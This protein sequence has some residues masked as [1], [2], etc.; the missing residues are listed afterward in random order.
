MRVHS[1]G[2]ARG[3][4]M[5][6]KS[7]SRASKIQVYAL[8]I[9]GSV[10]SLI[11]ACSSD[12]PGPAAGACTVGVPQSC[13][14]ATPCAAGTAPQAAC[15][16]DGTLGACTCTATQGVT[17]GTGG[18]AGRA[19]GVAVGT[20]GQAAGGAPAA[21]GGNTAPGTGGTGGSNTGPVAGGTGQPTGGTA[22]TPP[23]TSSNNWPMMGYDTNNNYHNPNEKILSVET[24]PM[25]KE[26]WRF[27]IAGYPPGTPII[28]DGRVF[29]HA[30][31]GTYG[32]SL[33]D[34][35]KLWERLDI[36]GTSSMGYA[37]G[38]VYVHV[39]N[40]DL[41]KLNPADGTTVWGPVKS[42]PTEGCDGESSP[43][44]AGG[45]VFVGHSC[46]P[47][48][49]GG[50]DFSTALGGVEA[51]DVETGE[52]K[53]TYYTVPMTGENGAMV[54]STVSVDVEAK[55]VFA[56]TGNNY[57]VQG[58]NSDAFHA[59]DMMTGTR[60]W[61]TQV[62]D[63][64]TW[65]LTG[66]PFGPDTD[67]GCNPILADIDGKKVAAGGEKGAAFHVFDRTTG[68]IVWQKEGLSSS[69]NAQNGGVLMNGAW[70]GKYFFVASNQPPGASVLHA[71][72]PRQQ[73]ADAWPPKTYNKLV[74]GAPAVANGVLAVPVDD[75][76]IILNAATGDQLAMFNMGGTFA[77][78]SPA[79]VDGNIVVASGLQ[80]ALD[81]SAKNNNEIIC[82][83]VPGAQAPVVTPGMG[84]AGSA[85]PMY[86]PGSP[87]WSAIYQ[88]IIVNTGCNGG[89]SCHAG[90]AGGRLVMTSKDE[91]YN[92]LVGVAAMGTAIAGGAANCADVGGQRVVAGDPAN[93]LLLD[94]VSSATPK[95]GTVM[96]PGGMLTPAQIQQIRD[97]IT[98]GAMNN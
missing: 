79:I 29:V 14:A 37:D 61:K 89:P 72:D 36:A 58:E 34:G 27:Q 25:L 10:A 24:A 81:P 84:A 97:W 30:T 54:W 75:D 86:V 9:V 6:G 98:A 87:T 22:G 67:F 17:A 13:V 59:I 2:D 51:F 23:T 19:G 50:G 15:L 33:A 74:W 31:G 45:M 1:V 77:A 3:L 71:L 18:N 85:A 46:G 11:G 91:G 7:A 16:P 80:Y 94:K 90:T 35:T 56:A 28:G 82:Y 68:E 12:K 73:G 20:G 88:E 48:E 64:D 70:D 42:F 55:V 41:Y 38:F 76:L 78:G 47:M 8:S 95:C 49:T 52:R 62:N 21:N 53:W 26:K 32:I 39:Y 5:N 60:L 57:T 40:T 44:I 63:D 65:S 92:A 66:A 4:M 83:A 43:I 69:R 93:S 96:P